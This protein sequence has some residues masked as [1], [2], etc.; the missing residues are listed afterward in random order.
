MALVARSVLNRLALLRSGKLPPHIYAA[1]ARTLRDVIYAPYQYSPVKDGSLEHTRTASE[2][3]RADAA[4]ALALDTTALKAA[5]KGAG[6]SDA[7]RSKLIAAT[8]F[9][10]P[11][12]F[13]DSSQAAGRARFGGHVFNSDSFASQHNVPAVF[14][15]VFA[16]QRRA[17]GGLVGAL[18]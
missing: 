17:A 15:T 4:I 14:E 3:K 16:P 6:V 2:L 1:L 5:L 8:G 12:A 7:N 9:R 11:D 18:R 13:H 10:T